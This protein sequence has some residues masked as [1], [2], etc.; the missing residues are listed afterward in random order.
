[1]LPRNE[2]QNQLFRVNAIGATV[3]SATRYLQWILEEAH[4]L[5]LASG[6]DLAALQDE[7]MRLL[8]KRV[9]RYT[10]G[11]S[12]S[13]R[14]EVADQILR[15]MFY[16]IGYYL[17]DVGE[18]QSAW[19]LLRT[20]S[21]A[22][23]H[24]AGQQEIKEDVASAH[25]LLARLQERSL[26]IDNVAYKDTLESGLSLFFASYDPEFGADETPGSIDYPLAD[27]R[28]DLTG[29]EFI[30][31]YLRKWAFE[32][33]FCR[34]FS[35]DA[36]DSLL[37]TYDANYQELLINV[38]G[39][40]VTNL[41][42][43]VLAGK[44]AV[45]LELETGDLEGVQLRYGGKGDELRNV[46]RAAARQIC[47]DLDIQDLAMASYVEQ[48]V[49]NLSAPLKD[50]LDHHRLETLLVC[51]KADV[52]M[53]PLRFEDG[54]WL[55]DETFRRI[56]DEIR[57]CQSVTDKISIIQ[58]E[59]HSMTDMVDLLGASCLF[60]DE[61]EA[62]YRS[63]DDVALALVYKRLP[64]HVIDPGLHITESE[65]AWQGALVRYLDEVDAA[66]G[67]RIRRLAGEI[68]IE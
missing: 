9:E 58:K 62:L 53:A 39:I 64:T 6:E 45:G 56:V 3:L 48:G 68:H 63:L 40:L 1:M 22:N 33:Q 16:S 24:K 12:S 46:L 31:D 49:L 20:Q 50:A 42:G 25:A 21:M 15:S 4:H 28:T 67:D 65:Q 14:V 57:D 59:I 60:D 47:D 41:V 8:A 5:G 66:R 17:K 10:G 7:S 55:D 2:Q 51:G 30:H 13:V 26:S 38:F 37:R 52:P 36:I 34:R 35:P 18:L 11:E 43:R 44:S 23:L 54:Q 32:D 61:F 29:I 19:Q 27:P